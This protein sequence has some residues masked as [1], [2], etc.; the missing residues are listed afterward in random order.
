MKNYTRLMHYNEYCI[1]MIYNFILK[2]HL[3]ASLHISELPENINSLRK[4]RAE[5]EH[6][7]IAQEAIV[8]LAKGLGQLLQKSVVPGCYKTSRR[9]LS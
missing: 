3:M 6:R 1:S 7:S 4:R 8:L 5:A 9:K 2:E